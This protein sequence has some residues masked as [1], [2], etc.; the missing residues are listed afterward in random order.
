MRGRPPVPPGGT[1]AA[2]A[3]PGP[4]PCGTAGPAPADVRPTADRGHFTVTFAGFTTL[5]RFAAPG[6]FD[7]LVRFAAPAGTVVL[8]RF[9]T[10]VRFAV[11]V[12][13][14]VLVRFVAFV[15]FAASVRGEIARQG[16][17]APVHPAVFGR[18]AAPGTGQGAVEVP[19]ARVAVVHDAG[20][21]CGAPTAFP[22]TLVK[23]V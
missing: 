17:C 6:R 1:V 20:R 23:V 11:R 10:P 21:L 16:R 7:M 5:V 18:C 15:R 19:L 8:V 13:F 9:A 3:A 2:L 22:G 14:T 12:R 4:G